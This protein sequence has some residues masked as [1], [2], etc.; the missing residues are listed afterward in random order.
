MYLQCSTCRIDKAPSE[1]Y[2]DSTRATGH[3]PRCK[4]CTAQAARERRAVL[5]SRSDEEILASVPPT[6]MC[7]KCRLVL[8][9]EEFS[10]TRSNPS[11]LKRTCRGCSKVLWQQWQKKKQG[12]G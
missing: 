6:Q 9:S 11:G 4:V 5:A 1:F 3:A 12:E 10:R 8:P 2:K 7:S